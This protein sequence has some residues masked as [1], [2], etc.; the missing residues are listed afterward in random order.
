M[1]PTPTKPH[2][3]DAAGDSDLQG[4]IT[5]G[6]EA[7]TAPPKDGETDS[8]ARPPL[9]RQ[10]INPI[11]LG[12]DLQPRNPTDLPASIK[13][14]GSV[15]LADITPDP[16]QPRKH[17]DPEALNDLAATLREHG[18]L[19]PLVL[20]RNPAA[21]AN[22]ELPPWILVS[23]E[24]RW[25][26]G[27]IAGFE[28]LPACE[29]R[30][31]SERQS[32]AAALIENVQRVDLNPIEVASHLQLLRVQGC[33]HDELGTLIGEASK[34]TVSKLLSLVDLPDCA[35]DAIRVG[36][37]SKS[38]GYLLSTAPT[39]KVE[40][41]VEAAIAEEWSVTR[42]KSE[43]DLLNKPPGKRAGKRALKPK[44]TVDPDTKRVITRLGEQYGTEVKIEPRKQG[45]LL[46]LKYAGIEEL[47]GI[48]ERMGYRDED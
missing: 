3:I 19:Q 23:G 2:E 39:A 5:P 47:N 29:M 32:A 26:A 40:T 42:L 10:D 36:K 45:G 30:V 31:A 48:L 44:S 12:A 7:T 4:A 34:G 1:T 16:S 14:L 8:R 17:F 28:E 20:R 33:S 13:P 27:Q 35:Q 15:A 6:S 24:R 22:P 37:L 38:H 21:E 43:I 9:A 25:R 18:L 41:L 11:E 46:I